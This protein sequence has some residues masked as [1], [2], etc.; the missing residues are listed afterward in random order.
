L[1]KDTDK[2]AADLQTEAT[3]GLLAEEDAFDRRMLWRLG[4][5]G[6]GAVGAVVVAV[7][8]NQSSLALKR[9]QVAA[10]DITRQA[11]QLQTLAK[12][13]H[14]ETRRLASAIDTLN[15]DRDR[16]YSRVTT[17]EQGLDSVTGAIAKQGPAQAA[18]APPPAAAPP[19]PVPAVGP[20]ATAPPAPT[21][22]PSSPDKTAA[23]DSKAAGHNE[24][25][26]AAADR[27]APAD[28]KPA[29][30]A[31]PQAVS[32][33]PQAV[34]EKPQVT[35][36][37]PPTVT[38]DSSS[39]ASA[40]AAPVAVSPAV[41]TIDNPDGKPS[42]PPP[43]PPLVA[44]KSLIGPPDPAASNLFAP[45]KPPTANDLRAMPMPEIANAAA[46][47]MGADDADAPKEQIKAQIQRTVFGVDLGIANSV[48][49]LRALW[50]GLLRAKANA[51]LAAL[52]PIIVIKENTGGL[53]MQLHLVAGPLNDAGTAAKI[54]AG[55]SMNQRTCE[56]AIYEGQRLTLKTEEPPA[57][58]KPFQ[59]H[60]RFAPKRA[61]APPPVVEEKKP[62]PTTFSSIFRRNGQ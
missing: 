2:L 15:S 6:V 25:P 32:D 11:Q 30:A 53:G 59:P 39:M 1:A 46:A 44:D 45:L 58:G 61:A 41:A 7:M 24:K 47:D 20:V 22:K 56:T 35:S 27:P 4:S 9:D 8:A 43:S 60:R 29:Q 17:L 21:E 48:N 54:C 40:S 3:S 37:R 18:A 26:A 38:S 10:A 5:W 42:A 34:S 16:L 57:A 14:S 12:E 49:G 50:R 62:E 55:L 36:D 52:Q 13:S 33:K 19:A 31:K 28:K 51:P 23:A